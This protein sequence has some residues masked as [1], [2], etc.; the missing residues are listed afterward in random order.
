MCR[1]RP[2]SAWVGF[3]FLLFGFLWVTLINSLRF[4]WSANPQYG[5]GWSVPLLSLYVFWRRWHERPSPAPP[6]S[7]FGPFLFVGILAGGFFLTRLVQE[8][9]PDWRLVSWLLTALVVGFSLA[10]LFLAGGWP[11]V[12]FFAFPV[13]FIFTAV[14]WPHVWEQALVQNLMRTVASITVELLSFIGIPSLQRGNV[15]EVGRGLIGIDQACS[16]VRSLQSTLM[17]SLFLGE[18]YRLNA[19][20]RLAFV[21]GGLGLAFVFNVARTFLLAWIGA[22]HGLQKLDHW[23]DQAGY[24]ILVLCFLV[25]WGFAV[26]FRKKP[27]PPAPSEQR[28]DAR[29]LSR[30]FLVGAALW[31]L[32]SAVNTEI[33]YRTREARLVD[34]VEWNINWPQAKLSYEIVPLAPLIESILAY[35]QGRAASWLESD[36]S[37]WTVFF[38]RWLPGSVSSRILARAHRPEQ[39]LTGAGQELKAD[40]G[41][42]L[43]RARGLEIPFRAYVFDNAGAPLHVFFCLW[44]DKTSPAD[45]WQFQGFIPATG[46]LK[47]VWDGKRRLLGQQ[48]LEI[49]VSGHASATAAEEALQSQLD[50]LIQIQNKN[51]ASGIREIHPATN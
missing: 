31:L 47:A 6:S 44:E 34:N 33:W 36:G 42:R 39:C 16:G 45:Q 40:L 25:L 7:R 15:I 13:A 41:V 32:L 2:S 19:R 30:R 43:L 14:P 1:S 8:A 29:P 26:R 20:L 17:S 4:D 37:R 23:H 10:S 28:S 21:A 24:S 9:N 11:W 51:A 46:R 38:F 3:G 35:D 49:V 50:Q 12:K 18:L 22:R 5:Y 27:L 48:T